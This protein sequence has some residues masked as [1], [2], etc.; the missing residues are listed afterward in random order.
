MYLTNINGWVVLENVKD[1]EYREKK[2]LEFIEHYYIPVT[3]N[4]HN[5]IMSYLH[6][7]ERKKKAKERNLEQVK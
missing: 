7:I 3:T 1:N 4:G 6:F 2:H 5:N